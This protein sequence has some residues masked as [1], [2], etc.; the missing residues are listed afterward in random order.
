MNLT[1]TALFH[2]KNK[3]PLR[4][5]G[6]NVRW[7]EEMAKRADAGERHAFKRKAQSMRMVVSAVYAQRVINDE[8]ALEA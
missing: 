7:F 8:Y 1:D 4:Q 5:L 6:Q 2:L 3:T